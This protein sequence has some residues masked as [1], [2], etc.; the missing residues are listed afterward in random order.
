[1]NKE[2]CDTFPGGSFRDWGSKSALDLHCKI[3]Y[4]FLNWQ[5]VSKFMLKIY[6]DILWIICEIPVFQPVP[7]LL[8]ENESGVRKRHEFRCLTYRSA[9][10][11]I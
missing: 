3:L 7:R 6:R 2:S 11:I 10:H 1:L 8:A 4:T 5:S 9:F